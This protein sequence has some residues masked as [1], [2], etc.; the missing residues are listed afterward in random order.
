MARR[1]TIVL[2]LEAGVAALLVVALL[3]GNRQDW[4]T[5]RWLLLIAAVVVA[6]VARAAHTVIWFDVVLFTLAIGG[7]AVGIR[8]AQTSPTPTPSQS[9]AVARATFVLPRGKVTAAARVG[10][11]KK[12]VVVLLD[13]ASSGNAPSYKANRY[14]AIFTDPVLPSLAEGKKAKRK[15]IRVT[16]KRGRK[17]ATA[18][19]FLADLE[20]AEKIVILPR[21]R[22]LPRRPK[23]KKKS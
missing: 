8:A 18:T 6:L 7:I 10:A 12:G 4:S 20:A 21:Q 5:Y 16:I 22:A 14:V 9:P 2:V 13:P 23:K 15:A 1:A 17:D 19:R 3:H 11:G